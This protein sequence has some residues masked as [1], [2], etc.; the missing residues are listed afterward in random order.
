M[1]NSKEMADSVFKIRDEY[2]EKQRKRM[3]G[4]KKA[5][6]IG[7]SFCMF[8]LILIG[9]NFTFPDK[10][11]IASLI[12]PDS[13]SYSDASEGETEDTNKVKATLPTDGISHEAETHKG[14]DELIETANS[15]PHEVEMHKGSGELIEST[16]NIPHGAETHKGS[17]ELIETTDSISHEGETQNGSDEPIETE[18]HPTTENFQTETDVSQAIGSEPAQEENVPPLDPEEIIPPHDESDRDTGGVDEGFLLGPIG[19]DKWTLDDIYR[20]FPI[21]SFEKQYR[22]RN[23]TITKDML[24]TAIADIT[25]TGSDPNASDNISADVVVYSFVDSAE[26][27]EIA[28]CFKDRNDYIVYGA[29]E[30]E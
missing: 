24:E 13:T 9:I 30:I 16:D 20:S 11:Q 6:S 3:R 7:S 21:I 17:G 22:C 8:G 29:E 28:I 26:N 2:L 4:L 27:E 15:I 1:K 12:V 25:V 19:F 5:A 10:Q 18:E 23:I 14:S